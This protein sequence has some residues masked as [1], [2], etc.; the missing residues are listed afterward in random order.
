MKRRSSETQYV[1]C[2]KNAG[3]KAS[4]VVRRIYP[5]IPDPDARKRG[6]LRV[7]DESG[8]DYLFPEGLFAAIEL[9]KAVGKMFSLAT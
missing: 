8:E 9:P 4:L 3:Y 2:V 1:V 6:L 7:L 5:V